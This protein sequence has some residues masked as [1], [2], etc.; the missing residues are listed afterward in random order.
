M[1]ADS[2]QAVR[3]GVISGKKILNETN[4]GFGI[5]AKGG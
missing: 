2:R 4:F 3:V 5:E 1:F